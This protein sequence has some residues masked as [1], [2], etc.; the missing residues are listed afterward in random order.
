MKVRSSLKEEKSWKKRKGR[1]QASDKQ[2]GGRN[3][4]VSD[5]L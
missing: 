1:G 5:V 4:D 3:D 2:S